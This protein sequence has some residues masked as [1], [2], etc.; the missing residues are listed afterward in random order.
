MKS[1]YKYTINIGGK[2]LMPKGA[3]ILTAQMQKRRLA[4]WALVDPSKDPDNKLELYIVPTGFIMDDSV[5][6]GLKYISTVQQNDG[7]YV[8]HV[9]QK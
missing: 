1:I 8:W 2:L 6:K 7:D 4:I 3:Q 5:A 9:F